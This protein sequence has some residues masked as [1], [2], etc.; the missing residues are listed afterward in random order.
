MKRILCLLSVLVFT[1]APV[2][3][4][5]DSIDLSGMTYAEL[6]ALK[7]KIN[8][9]IWNSQEWQEVTVPQGV[10]KVGEDIPAG[11]WTVICADG[12][13]NTEINWGEK[14]S[15]NGES[16]YWSGRYSVYNTI[17]NPYHSWYEIG[18]GITEY[19]F[20]VRNGDYIVVKD[21][22]CVFMPYVGKPNLGFK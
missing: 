15:E 21:G 11:H 19:S 9:A 6:I 20:E 1:L 16:I 13:R 8:F 17:Y 4:A 2:A 14:L 10:W 22:S 3:L 12:W 5:D 18:D 7:N